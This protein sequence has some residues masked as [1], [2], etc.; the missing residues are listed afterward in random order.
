[1][2]LSP[3]GLSLPDSRAGPPYAQNVPTAAMVPV[4]RTIRTVFK[5]Q[6]P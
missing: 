6:Y 1:M 3:T 4:S 5:K 2:S